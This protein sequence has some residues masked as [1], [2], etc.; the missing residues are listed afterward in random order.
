MQTHLRLIL[1]GILTW[2]IPFGIS[3]FLYGPDGTLTIGIFAFKSLMIISGAAVGA[4]LIY[5]YLRSLPS[6]TNWLSAGIT[7]GISWLLINWALDLLVIV[8]LFGM[9]GPEWFIEIGSRYLVIPAMAI[10]AG[11]TAELGREKR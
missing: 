2:L 7:I 9:G 11:A 8:A 3:L 6:G 10:L 1:Y 4:L 5:L